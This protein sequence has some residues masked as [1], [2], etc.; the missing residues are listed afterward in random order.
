MGK[1]YNHKGIHERLGAYATKSIPVRVD[2][3]KD[4]SDKGKET[5]R[6]MGIAPYGKYRIP[7]VLDQITANAMDLSSL[8]HIQRTVMIHEV[9]SGT[10]T[11]NISPKKPKK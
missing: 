5:G 6:C 2:R 9:T 1:G 3:V 8:K 7:G 11:Y 10:G 4:Y